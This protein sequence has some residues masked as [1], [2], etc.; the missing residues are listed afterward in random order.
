[1]ANSEIKMKFSL[2]SSGVK[3]ALTRA[4]DSVNKFGQ[5]SFQRLNNLAKY[6]T[7]GFVAAFAAFSRKAI[8]LGSE[9]SDIAEST[10]FA[11]E[12]F[13]VFRGALI[14]AGGK[15]ESMEKSITL[16]QKAIVQGSEGLTTYTRAFERI[17]LSVDDLRQMK[18]EQQF[19]AIARGIASAEDQQGALTAAIEIFG[20]RNAPRL[21]EVFRRLNKDGYGKM[22]ED[23]KAAYG[24]MDA[25]TQRLLDR[26]ADQIER[27][28]NK[29]TI[30]V[31]ELIAGEANYAAVKQ[32]GYQLMAVL[33]K[34]G[35]SLR[36]HLRALGNVIQAGIGGTF[37]LV[38]SKFG[39]ALNLVVARMR[40]GVMQI[41]QDLQS[42]INQI[43]GIE[44]ELVDTSSAYDSLRAA[45]DQAAKDSGK[46]WN[47][48]F[49]D[50]IQDQ[51]SLADEY[52]SFWTAKANEQKSLIDA[53]RKAS[54]DAKEA[55]DSLK[56]ALSGDGSTSTSA[57]TGGGSSAI[58]GDANASGYVT[59][60]E[61]RA[62]ERAQRAADTERRRRERDERVAEVGAGER[63]RSAAG[64]ARMSAR[65]AAAGFGPGAAKKP[66]GMGADD[67]KESETSKE[68]KRELKEQTKLLTTIKEEIQKNP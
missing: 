20:Q 50:N 57:S 28:K 29:A 67:K 24:I 14:D 37:D 12:E 31:G 9:L 38:S 40:V 27:F 13:Q 30:Y 36:D 52:E 66:S 61:Q 25:E 64:Y 51:E 42:K 23:I 58:S 5:Q 21:M 46:T 35:G 4:Q 55:G 56:S 41:I 32:L 7:G 39:N 34:F 48:F 54:A 17:G 26:A 6:V 18:P 44:V 1:M 65:E 45:M 49:T 47:D 68:T 63:A 53:S 8:G 15:A 60:R 16:M 22:A 10:G 33:G 59:P 11:T 3:K 43:P 19:E 62:Q 2:D